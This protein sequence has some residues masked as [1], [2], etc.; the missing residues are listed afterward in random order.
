MAKQQVIALY[1]GTPG[2][3]LSKFCQKFDQNTGIM[4]IISQFEPLINAN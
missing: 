3:Q 4:S 2:G 1:R